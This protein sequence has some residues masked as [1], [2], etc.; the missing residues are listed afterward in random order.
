VPALLRELVRVW[1]DAERPAACDLGPTLRTATLAGLA[2]G[3]RPG[4]GQ[5]FTALQ[6]ADMTAVTAQFRTAM[7][8]DGE[9]Y[10]SNPP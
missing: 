9:P 6:V 7:R 3:G 4:G 5:D 1:V 10:T 2:L 8:L